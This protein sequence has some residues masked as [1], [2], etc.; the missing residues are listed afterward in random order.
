MDRT[1]SKPPA[2]NGTSDLQCPR[3]R[4]GTLLA[5]KRGWGCSRWREGCTFVVWFEVAGKRL[6]DTQL[7]ELVLKGRTR[8]TQWPAAS[9]RVAGRLVLDLDADRDRGAA[10][11]ERL[12]P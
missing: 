6:S 12:D 4:Q 1:A 10:R 8:K 3:C 9:G 5:G 11:F 2:A 7:R